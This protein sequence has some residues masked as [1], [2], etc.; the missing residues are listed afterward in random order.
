MEQDFITRY[1]KI[2][3]YGLIGALVLV[4]GYFAYDHYIKKPEQQKAADAIWRAE[5][6][7][8]LDSVNLALNGDGSSVGF[9]NIISKYGGTPAGNLAKFYAGSSYMK[10]GDYENAIKY[11]KDFNSKDKLIMVRTYGLIGDAYAELGNKQEAVDYY[12]KA[13]TYYADDNFNSPEYLFRA[14]LLYQELNNNS[15][16]VKMFTTIKDKYPASQYGRE[17]EK[18]LGRLGE[19]E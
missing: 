13:G 19:F 11:L 8:R 17:I 2:A 18:Y 15:E 1:G 9:L 3:V 12:K 4:G 7:Y 10:L 14:G 6:L 5:E 16:A